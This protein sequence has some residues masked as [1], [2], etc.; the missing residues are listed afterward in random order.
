MIMKKLRLLGGIVRRRS[1]AYTRNISNIYNCN[2]RGAICC[3]LF[4]FASLFNCS[5]LIHG[6]G[7]RTFNMLEEMGIQATWAI[8]RERWIR[9]RKRRWFNK[10]NSICWRKLLVSFL[11]SFLVLSYLRSTASSVFRIDRSCY[12]KADAQHQWNL[13]RQVAN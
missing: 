11:V 10:Y 3:L 2:M 9:S 1:S 12:C 7:R 5:M 6:H 8:E 4:A 13:I